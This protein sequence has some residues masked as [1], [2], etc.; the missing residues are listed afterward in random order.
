MVIIMIIAVGHTKGGVGK[1]TLA[2]Q[3]ASYLKHKR[4][5]RP[6]IWLV[7]AD[8]Q[9]SA[10]K[11]LIERNSSNLYTKIA[12]ASYTEGKELF[13]QISNQEHLWN[14][15]I[16]DIGAR[17]S[18]TFRSALMK[19]DLLV[20][21]VMPR[22][23]DLEALNELYAVLEGAWGVGASFEACAVLSCADQNTTTNQE[24][25]EYITTNFPKIKYID[26]PVMRRKATGLASASGLS[27]FESKP[28]D[29]KACAEIEKLVETIYPE[30]KEE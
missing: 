14:D 3:I 23:F 27:V 15:I 30:P 6:N 22:V 8:S 4:L 7:D 10:S 20:I 18:D 1:S 9:R 29:K 5:Y 26:A 2:I 19:A 13:Q 17:D 25:I 21:P 24:A 28:V 12:A 11:A 16:I